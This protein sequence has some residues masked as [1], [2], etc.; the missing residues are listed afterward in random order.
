MK[1]NVLEPPKKPLYGSKCNGCGVCCM[2]ELC[3]PAKDIFPGKKGPCPLLDF[4]DERFECTMYTKAPP[5][6]KRRIGEALGINDGCDT[7]L[8][9]E[10]RREV[11][12]RALHGDKHAMDVIEYLLTRR[13]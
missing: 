7:L 4:K 10:D 6:L 1:L 2:E 8:N 5:R 3:P 9:H 13:F 11:F 12:R